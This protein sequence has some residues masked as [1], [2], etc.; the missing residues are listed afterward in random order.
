LTIERYHRFFRLKTKETH[1]KNPAGTNL[2]DRDAPVPVW[3]TLYPATEREGYP[4]ITIVFNPGHRLGEQALKNR[5]HRI[6]E[7]TREVWSGEYHRTRSYGQADG[8]YDYGDA[9]PLLLTTL[10]RLQQHG[11]HGPVWWRCGHGRWETLHDALDNP[12]DHDTWWEREEER[13]RLHTEHTAR[14]Q[15][16]RQQELKQWA[17]AARTAAPIPAPAPT[18]APPCERCQQ[19][20]TG[21]WGTSDDDAPPPDGRHCPECRIDIAA[22]PPPC[23]RCCSSAEPLTRTATARRPDSLASPAGPV[24]LGQDDA[25]TCSRCSRPLPAR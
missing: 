2:Q 9:I 14:E 5:M 16:H 22:H 17:P 6:M 1:G 7:A 3:R 4:P 18:L 19:P 23:A 21:Q 25:T 20:I 24:R 8:Y 11:P 12:H 13:R 15:E 10:P